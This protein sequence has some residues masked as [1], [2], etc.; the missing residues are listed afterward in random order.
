[1][2]LSEVESPRWRI[3]RNRAWEEMGSLSAG[4]RGRGAGQATP[5]THLSC[6]YQRRVQRARLKLDERSGVGGDAKRLARL[7]NSSRQTKGIEYSG[8]AIEHRIESTSFHPSTFTPASF[9]NRSTAE[10]G[11]PRSACERRKRQREKVGR[12]H[13]SPPSTQKLE[14]WSP[15][16]VLVSL[17]TRKTAFE[18][19]VESEPRKLALEGERPRH[20]RRGQPSKI[21]LTGL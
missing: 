4:Y 1:M 10:Q 17:A 14:C 8:T 15:L 11:A 19:L 7:K 20:R 6:K 5:E 2:V 12:A 21:L 16:T 9:I 18:E 13:C 3:E